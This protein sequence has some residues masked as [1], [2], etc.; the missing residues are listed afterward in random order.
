M[1]VDL[2]GIRE[3]GEHEINGSFDIDGSSDQ[4]AQAIPAAHIGVV[5]VWMIDSDHDKAGIGQGLG[6]VMMAKIPAAIAVRDDHERQPFSSNRAIRNRWNRERSD[7][8]FFRRFDARRPHHRVDCRTIP[9]ARDVKVF[10]ACRLRSRHSETKSG[11]EGQ[12]YACHGDC[13]D[14]RELCGGP[15]FHR[16]ARVEN[17]KFGD[18]GFRYYLAITG[19][20]L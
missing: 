3:V 13:S 2:G 17:E 11:R 19:S 6:R 7:L 9:P 20:V 5:C 4:G 16:A 10:Q 18:V 15:A 1:R 12:A 8:H 14:P